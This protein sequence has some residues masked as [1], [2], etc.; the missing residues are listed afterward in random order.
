MLNKTT[1]NLNLYYE[2]SGN[3]ESQKTLVFLNGLSQSTIAWGFVLPHFKNE[4]KFVALDFI[5][6]G[7]SDKNSEKRDFDQHASQS[8]GSRV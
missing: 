1:D 3:T 6:P 5:L 4:Y 8:H 2:V 7:K